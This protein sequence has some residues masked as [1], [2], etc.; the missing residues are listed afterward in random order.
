MMWR[1]RGGVPD[2]MEKGGIPP[3]SEGGRGE[4]WKGDSPI[5]PPYGPYELVRPSRLFPSIAHCRSFGLLRL[6][7]LHSS[8]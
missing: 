3:A 6:L 4:F 7:S 1:G 8:G 2:I 5:G